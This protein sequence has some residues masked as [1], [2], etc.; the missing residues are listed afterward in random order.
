MHRQELQGVHVRR[1]WHAACTPHSR[2]QPCLSTRTHTHTPPCGRLPRTRTN[3]MLPALLLSA[4]LL[5]GS[6]WVTPASAA[7]QSMI[8]TWGPKRSGSTL[9]SQVLCALAAV[10]HPD[11]AGAIECRWVEHLPRSSRE[12]RHHVIKTHELDLVKGVVEGK[13]FPRVSLFTTGEFSA[14][15]AKRPSWFKPEMVADYETVLRRGHAPV[16]EYQP[17]F[18]VSV[19]DMTDVARYMEVWEVL[20]L[21]CGSQ[22]SKSYR[23]KLTGKSS[24]PHKCDMYDISAVEEALLRTSIVRRFSAFPN[25]MQTL[26]KVSSEDSLLDGTYCERC[27]AGEGW[28]CKQKTKKNNNNWKRKN[29]HKKDE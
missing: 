16:W 20:R 6:C 18:N 15:D 3:A 14:G 22:M 21:C 12:I 1:A 28:G 2:D 25:L 29:K 24:A 26:K 11:D 4:M 19:Q 7:P 23:S 13:E 10:A 9:Q 5:G 8:V 27:D 17:F